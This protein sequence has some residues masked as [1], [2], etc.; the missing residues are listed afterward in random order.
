M[1]GKDQG[2]TTEKKREVRLSESRLLREKYLEKYSWEELIRS[3]VKRLNSLAFVG[4]LGHQEVSCG[5]TAPYS[6]SCRGTYSGGTMVLDLPFLG[7]N[8]G[9]KKD[10]VETPLHLAARHP[11]ADMAKRLLDD[12]ADA[13]ARDR[14]NRAPLHLAIEYD[15]QG[16]FQLLIRNRATDLEARMDDGTT[17]LILAAR[18]DLLNLVQCLIKAGVK[19][20]IADNQGKTA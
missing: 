17:P 12:G 16:V 7:A 14:F 20:N 2:G 4:E 6:A 11:R 10:L 13:N 3:L 19:V 18:H 5:R 15:A 9:S 8:Y 1:G